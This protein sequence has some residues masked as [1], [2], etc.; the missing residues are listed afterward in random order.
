MSKYFKNFNWLIVVL[1]VILIVTILLAIL[2]PNP[3]TIG[4]VIINILN[5]AFY[6]DGFSTYYYIAFRARRYNALADNYNEGTKIY[7]VKHN[8]YSRGIL[9]L[10]SVE[11]D[12]R[13]SCGIPYENKNEIFIMIT[14]VVKTTKD[15]YN[16]SENKKVEK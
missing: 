10:L 4:C 1:T 6:Y 7:Q 14:N 11:N 12:I 16:Y 5:L 13:E 2:V 8:I 9:N 3:F 15:Y